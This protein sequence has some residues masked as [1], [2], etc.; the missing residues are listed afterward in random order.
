MGSNL[1]PDVTPG[2]VDEAFG[3]PRKERVMGEVTV[4]VEATV[5]EHL[6]GTER[7]EALIDAYLDGDDGSILN[8]SVEETEAVGYE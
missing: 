7:E 4:H 5:P 6:D 2:D 1:P 8:A 3:P